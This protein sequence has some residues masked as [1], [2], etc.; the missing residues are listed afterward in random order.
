MSTPAGYSRQVDDTRPRF[1]PS[2]KVGN[3]DMKI[4]KLLGHRRS[5]FCLFLTIKV[6]LLTLSIPKS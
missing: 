1:N 6:I 2:E 3:Q 5:G 4:K